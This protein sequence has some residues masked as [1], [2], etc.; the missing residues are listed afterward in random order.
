MLERRR[1]AC[2]RVLVLL[3]LF[4]FFFIWNLLFRQQQRLSS[5]HLKGVQIVPQLKFSSVSRIRILFIYCLGSALSV[6]ISTTST[7]EKN[8]SSFSSSYT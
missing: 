8:H 3:I 2:W 1:L 6:S 4:I 7:I 5:D